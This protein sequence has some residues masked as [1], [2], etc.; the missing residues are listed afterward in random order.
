MSQNSERI[1]AL[2]NMLAQELNR[3]LGGKKKLVFITPGGKWGEYTLLFQSLYA[4]AHFMVN[5]TDTK[6]TK[7]QYTDPT[8]TFK[9]MNNVMALIRNRSKD[10][11]G[12]DHEWWYHEDGCEDHIAD[13]ESYSIKDMRHYTPM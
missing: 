8:N 11:S 3:K 10:G 9:I 2:G 13:M 12:W 5:C 4:A 6:W 7:T 1:A